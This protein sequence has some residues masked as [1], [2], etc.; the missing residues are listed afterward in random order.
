MEDRGYNTK[1][2]KSKLKKKN[3]RGARNLS[4]ELLQTLRIKKE[5]SPEEEELMR[6]LNQLYPLFGLQQALKRIHKGDPVEEDLNV[7]AAFVDT[8]ATVSLHPAIVGE[9]VASIAEEVNQHKHT[10]TC[11]KYNTIC[12][13][14][15]PK[16]PAYYTLVARCPEATMTE[17]E[18]RKLEEEY[19]KVIE[20]VQNV[21]SDNEKM[22]S[23]LAKY[24]KENEVT[25]EEAIEGRHKR[26][27]A[28]LELAQVDR[29]TYQAVLQYSTSG[30]NVVM[31]RDIDEC[32]VNSYNPEIT[33]AWQGNTD[34]QIC[35]DFFA[36]ISYI[37]EYYCK[38]DQGIIKT[39][40]NTL[41]ASKS[42][43]LK[44]EMRL[45][46]NTWIKNRQMGEAEAVYR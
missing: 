32:S 23:I 12:R 39:L 25:K 35:L 22:K 26:I 31:A 10:K 20:K 27:D 42:Q 38:D 24:P 37:T 34:F 11:R 6:D 46:A 19:S 2:K 17:K 8:F 14:K 13:F 15:F 1:E 18:R 45:L 40:V 41:K 36:I 43:D 4:L 5:Q 3:R 9:K 33:R 16:L 7:V 28:L 44:K 29:V 30:Y 21:L